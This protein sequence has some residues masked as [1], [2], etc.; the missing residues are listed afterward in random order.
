MNE[1]TAL[2]VDDSKT[3]RFVLKRMLNLHGLD[4]ATA[5]SAETA[6]EYLNHNLPDIIFMD[7]MM[8]GMDGLQAVAIIKDDPRTAMIPIVMYTSRDGEVYVGQARALGAVDVLP[9]EVQAGQIYDVLSRLRLIVP[10]ETD[11]LGDTETGAHQES[12]SS[13]HQEQAVRLVQGLSDMEIRELA[14]AVA[15][16]VR[17]PDFSGGLSQL[18][19][20]QRRS[21]KHDF[22]E[23]LRKANKSLIDQLAAESTQAKASAQ[24]EETDTHRSAVIKG[25]FW[26][27]ALVFLLGLGSYAL[28][29]AFMVGDE[30]SASQAQMAQL[31]TTIERLDQQNQLLEDEL[32]R[33]AENKSLLDH[34][35][36]RTIEWL[37]NRQLGY[38]YDEVALNETR[39]AFIQGLTQRLDLA[40]FRG[41]IVLQI[42]TGNFCFVT[43][44]AGEIVLAEKDLPLP[45]CEQLGYPAS[46]AERLAARQSLAFA[47]FVETSPIVE[48]G[49]INVVIDAVGN[50]DGVEPYPPHEMVK[51]AGEWNN[52]ALRNNRIM[53][54]LNSADGR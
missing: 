14:E 3:D 25:N 16:A 38:N 2:V 23:A 15:N 47:H 30:K 28:V 32:D 19:S 18:L 49:R 10:P 36:V 48:S 26:S 42:S 1:K 35:M 51:T 46:E 12:M 34:E 7:H 13:H 44:T 50:E 29:N 43:N 37:A 45:E 39:T 40:G 11:Q 9:K 20:E 27:L 6:L 8:P 24:P 33:A 41:E 52:V 31:Q 54:K 17:V 21:V 4:V 53:L 22:Q 5:D